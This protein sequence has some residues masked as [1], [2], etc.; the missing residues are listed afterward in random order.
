MPELSIIVPV[1]NT[2]KYLP[3]CLDS[4]IG[5]SLKDIEIICIDDGS[6]DSSPVILQNYAKKD[7][8]IHIIRKPNGGLVSARKAGVR[9]AKGKYIGYV[10]SDDWI[11]PTMY[12]TLY[13]CAESN[14]AD[15]VSSGYF[16]EGNYITVHYD[17]VPEGLYDAKSIGSLREKAIY[18]VETWDVGIRGSLCCKLFLAE[19]FRAVQLSIPEEI[20]M[21]EDKLCVISFLLS[22]SRVYVQWK[23]FYHY[24]IHRESMVN[25]PDCRYL[26]K[27]NAVYQYLIT[28]YGHPFF[29]KTM[30]LQA[31]LYITE[32]LYKGINSRL[33]FENRDLFWVDPYWL[34]GIPHGSKVALYGAGGLG[35]AYKR[36]LGSR[37]DLTYAGCT[38]FGWEKFKG[39]PMEVIPPEDLPQTGYDVLVI[40]I[41]NPG[42]AQEVR[43]Q[44]EGIGIPGHKILWF[45]QKEIYWKYAE[46]NGWIK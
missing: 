34:N 44:L 10:D 9:E 19:K 16:F 32:M 31:E 5:Q 33:G 23:A 1:Y 25:M 37:G 4:I 11:D 45:E 15:M 13:N 7:S 22:C 12:E 42:K 6:T 36:Q 26:L 38:D 3:R 46:V 20:S 30:R 18:N 28:L 40:T 29:T 8:R 2:E 14:Q 24:I 17:G 27:V 21:S 41:K 39:G 35:H 43:R